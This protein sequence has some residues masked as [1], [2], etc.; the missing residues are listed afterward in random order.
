MRDL[1][2]KEKSELLTG[3]ERA[4]NRQKKNNIGGG[5]VTRDEIDCPS[6]PVIAAPLQGSELTEN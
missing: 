6:P 5:G 2:E 3:L 4:R 1:N